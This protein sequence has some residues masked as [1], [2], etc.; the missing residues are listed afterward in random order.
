MI[1]IVRSRVMRTR[2]GKWK[3][4]S[5]RGKPIVRFSQCP[6]RQP[7]TSTLRLQLYNSRGKAIVTYHRNSLLFGKKP[8]VDIDEEALN[9]LD[10][11]IIGFLVMMRDVERWSE[12]EVNAVV[13]IV[14]NA[15]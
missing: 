6:H 2:H 12:A 15:A 10:L 3:W 14:S 13:G 9:Y 11:V 5:S 4:T 8:T 7:A 1:Y